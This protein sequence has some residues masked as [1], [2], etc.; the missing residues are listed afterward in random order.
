MKGGWK[1]CSRLVFGLFLVFAPHAAL[2]T[3]PFPPTCVNPMS[4]G[5]IPNDGGD[6]REAFQLAVDYAASL[7]T[8]RIVCI[9]TG[10]WDIS[11]RTSGTSKIPSI[12][13]AGITGLLITGAGPNTVVRMLGEGAQVP[14]GHPGDWSLI[15]I[16]DGSSKIIVRDMTLDG[17]QRFNTQEQ[18]HL[19]HLT[20]PVSDIL[21]EG[22]T[23]DFPGG[24]G[25]KGGDCIRL[26]GGLNKQVR[27]VTLRYLDGKVCDRSFIGFQCGVYNVLVDGVH[28]DVVGDHSIDSELCRGVGIGN[29]TIV[30][31]QFT[32]PLRLSGRSAHPAREIT[33]KDSTVTGGGLIIRHVDGLLV[34]N[35]GVEHMP[36]H[37]DAVVSVTGIARR[38]AFVNVHIT[39]SPGSTAGLVFATNHDCTGTGCYSRM[40]YCSIKSH[41]VSTQTT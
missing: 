6:D 35:V 23:F 17:T 27:G 30:N 36:G 21:V 11:R 32:H 41:S 31:S 24:P 2:A 13:V 9:P 15:Q 38:V 39:R 5:A 20:G 26:Q 18:T 12:E 10:I 14:G 37:S 1:L 28:N 19:L 16:R 8:G 7:T 33:L 4:F 34:E 29:I 22:I 25:L 3:E 40:M